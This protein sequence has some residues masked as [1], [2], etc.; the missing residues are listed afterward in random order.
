MRRFMIPLALIAA[1]AAAGCAFSV[2]EGSGDIIT[3]SRPV[4]GIRGV[5]LAGSGVLTI[6]V[7]QEEALTIR[8]DDN[9]LEYIETEVRDGSLW[10][11]PKRGVKNLVLRPTESFRFDLTVRE[12]GAIAVSGSGTVRAASLEAESMDIAVSGSG[13]VDIAR[14]VAERV[15]AA[16]SGS[17]DVT[18]GGEVSV[19]SVAISGSGEYRADELASRRAQCSISGSGDVTMWVEER[20]DV[21]VSGTGTVSYYGDP[22]VEHEISGRGTVRKLGPRRVT[23]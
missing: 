3:E 18:I 23:L 7:G 17:G 1:A 8:A 20:L 13:Q 19:Q 10:I 9:L 2:V 21:N 15:A 16:I 4:G 22:A 12:L 11:G 5:A 14:L 6:T